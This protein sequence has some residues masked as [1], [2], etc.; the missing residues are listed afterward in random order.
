MIAQ[1]IGQVADKYSDGGGE[2]NIWS[3]GGDSDTERGTRTGA[4]WGIRT[5]QSAPKSF[6]LILAHIRHLACLSYDTTK[7]LCALADYPEWDS[8]LANI[9]FQVGHR[10]FLYPEYA[11]Y[12]TPTQQ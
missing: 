11:H 1:G 6:S 10:I 4:C 2:E 5:Q 9:L 8:L 12:F 7:C 3:M